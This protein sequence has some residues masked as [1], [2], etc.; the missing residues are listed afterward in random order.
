MRATPKLTFRVASVYELPFEDNSFEAVATPEGVKAMQGHL[1]PERI[2]NF[3]RRLFPGQIPDR[4][5]IAEPLE[6]EELELQGHKLAAGKA[7]WPTRLPPP[8]CTSPR[9]DTP[10]AG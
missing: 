6:D 4:L 2:E 10:V 7:G 8:P 3:W 9:L 1:A 5:L